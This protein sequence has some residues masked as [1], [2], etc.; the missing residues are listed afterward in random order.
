MKIDRFN[1]SRYKYFLFLV[2]IFDKEG[3]PIRTLLVNYEKAT[4][5]EEAYDY[6]GEYLGSLS[7]LDINLWYIK[8]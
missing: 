5:E 4:P 2:I 3:K 6:G 7:D 1:V 8:F